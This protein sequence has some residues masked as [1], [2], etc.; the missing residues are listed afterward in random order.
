MSVRKFLLLYLAFQG[1]ASEKYGKNHEAG[2]E[3]I[4]QR[5]ILTT[6]RLESYVNRLVVSSSQI[7]GSPCSSGRIKAAYLRLRRT[8]RKCNTHKD[9]WM[10]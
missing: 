8:P 7:D 2:T 9:L 6:Y 3:R 5:S 4:A 1:C 10:V